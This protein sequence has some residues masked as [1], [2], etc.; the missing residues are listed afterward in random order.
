MKLLL[1]L[2]ALL[3]VGVT[4]QG[5]TNA[6]FPDLTGV[7]PS[8]IINPPKG[9]NYPGCFKDMVTSDRNGDGVIT[10]NEYLGFIQ[11]YGKRRCWEQDKL[12]LEQNAVFNALACLCESK[13]GSSPDCCLGNNARIPNAGALTPSTR[14]EEELLS[15]TATCVW[16]D[17]TI[18]GECPPEVLVRSTPPPV[19]IAPVVAAGSG[20]L[21]DGA[22]WGIIAAAIAA[23]LLLLLLCCC[24]CVLR[25]RKQKQL[26]EEEDERNTRAVKDLE[27]PPEQAPEPAPV[28]PAMVPPLAPVADEE[29]SS[30]DGDDRGLKGDNEDDDSYDG[31]GRR[32]AGQ[33]FA[34]PEDPE[35][36]RRIRGYG[37]LPPVV[38]PEPERVILRPIEKEEEEPE[39][40]DYPG[41]DINF[42][43]PEPDEMSAQEFEPY[44]P[45]GG[46][47]IPQHP[48]RDPIDP[49][50]RDWNRPKPVIPD[51]TDQRKHRIQAG[52]GEGEVWDK[53]NDDDQS[54]NSGKGGVGDVFDWVVQSAL[55]VL[56]KSD[57]AGHL[58]DE[59]ST[60]VP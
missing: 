9:I 58:D 56:D 59:G 37:E 49:P 2:P 12:T 44:V 13:E 42:P 16:T 27:A 50:N 34:D 38:P 25:R 8:L 33:N 19:L 20:G 40:W 52:L 24:C 30:Y 26:E 1:L 17:A 39:E 18:G 23:L 48:P 28:V 54:Q 3:L 60:Q 45:D 29:E 31:E 51:E 21:S 22:K 11:E 10:Q 46:V 43:K 32:K 35:D 6:E 14:T 4:A 57:E 5:S 47:H 55:G 36:A 7:D 15:L 41:R 53:L